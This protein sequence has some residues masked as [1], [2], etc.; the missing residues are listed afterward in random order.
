[1]T[2]WY[3]HYKAHPKTFGEREFFKQVGKTFKGLDITKEQFQLILSAIYTNLRLERDDVL[4]DLCC[5]N[6]IIT[7][8]LSK[9]C[10][11]I[12]GVDYSESLIEIAKKYNNLENITYLEMSAFDLDKYFINIEKPFTKVLMYEALQHFQKKDV[13]RLIKSIEAISSVDIV[14]YFG[15]I[16]DLKRKWNFYNTPKR[17]F[18]YSLRRIYG[19]ELIGTWW[20]SDYI[21]KICTQNGLVC[22]IISQHKD[23]Y[24]SHYRFDAIITSINK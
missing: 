10:G 19:K 16:P 17:K 11:T 23:L 3:Q 12:I 15:S 14:I 4:L 5:G 24:T 7:K 6:G 21:R 9:I 22:N 1:M 8:E 13:L 20:D 18:L 2:D